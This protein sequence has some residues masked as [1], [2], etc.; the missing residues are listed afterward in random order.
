[1]TNARRIT[2]S[3]WLND[4]LFIGFDGI[5]NKLETLNKANTSNYPPYNLIKTG[6]DSYLIELAVAGF[7]EDDLDITV[8]DGILTIKGE[9][10][11]KDT[12]ATY[13]HRAIATR[14]FVRTFTLADTI[15]VGSAQIFNGMLQIRLEIIIPE[16]KKPQKIHINGSTPKEFLLG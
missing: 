16:S 15:V 13:L 12:E 14:N 6:E 7:A 4:P 2:T 1:M 5:F 8:Q 3:S 9:V 10:K 11:S